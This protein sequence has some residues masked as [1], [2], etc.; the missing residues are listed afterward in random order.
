M[1]SKLL[2]LEALRAAMKELKFTAYIIPTEDPHMSEYIADFHTRRSYISG[3]TGSA[4]L[5][6]VTLDK[7]ALWT[8]GRYFLQASQQL[9]SQWTL[10]KAGLPNVPT[11]EEWLIQV[12]PAQS[13]VAI[14]PTLFTFAAAKLLKEKLEG[15]GHKLVSSTENLV[16]KVWENRPAPP[17]NSIIVLD[18]KYAG[19]SYQEKIS[20]LQKYLSENS[21]WGLVVSALDEIA[22]L[23]N[24]RGSDIS[25]NPVFLSYAIVTAD[26]VFL[27][28]DEKKV[29]SAMREHLGDKVIIKPY[30]AVFADLKSKGVEMASSDKKPFDTKRNP[31]QDAKAIKNE[32][33]LEGFRQSH[34]RDAAALCRYFS[35]LEDE[36]VNKKNT[37]ITEAS[38]A[39]KLEKFRS[40]LALFKGLSFDTISSTGPNEHGTCATID[41]A[42][43][44]LCDSGGQYLD[45]TTDVTRTMHFG[46]PTDE[47][48]DAFTRVLKGHMGIDML[49]FPKGTTGYIIDSVARLSLWKAGLDFRH[50]TGHGVGAFLNVHEG[51]HGIGMRVSQNEVGL[52]PGMTVTNEPGFYKDGAFGIR[53]EN[54]LLVK[55]AN[56]PNRF[57]DV[58][59]HC[60][61]HV[62]VV[63]IQTKLIEK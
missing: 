49:V 55:L 12:L 48:K 7:A 9:T 35:W 5:A 47:E 50:G 4:G 2:P 34:K 39:D 16:D 37:S 59:Y 29:T 23:F 32:V 3:F 57:G 27:Y 38:A 14:D 19:K 41:P 15:K 26:G 46:T 33:E 56:T 1:S 17:S 53:I 63:P 13:T 10:Q 45:G 25:F 42:Q 11:K 62:T 44:Y 51:P 22:W 8:D 54:V 31:I 60:F 30:D 6:V 20:D 43:M 58:D 52:A 61:E 24:L 18:T 40:E 36:L 28:V 21:Y